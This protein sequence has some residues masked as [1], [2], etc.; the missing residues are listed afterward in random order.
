M[1][2]HGALTQRARRGD[3]SRYLM[4]SSRDPFTCGTTA[5]F[6]ELAGDFKRQGHQVILFLVE[7]GVFAARKG[8]RCSALAD[9]LAAGV[10]VLAEDF[11]LQQRAIPSSALRSGIVSAPLDRVVD[12]LAARTK[13]LWH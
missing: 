2:Y 10:T 6:Y 5:A 9:V 13:A 7:N 3:M 11:A 1:T 4:I 8:T 12:E